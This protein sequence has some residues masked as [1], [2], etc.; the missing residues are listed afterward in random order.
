[1]FLCIK[2]IVWISDFFCLYAVPQ[3][4]FALPKYYFSLQ[5]HSSFSS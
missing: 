3:I 2:L 1:M 4:H 5:I